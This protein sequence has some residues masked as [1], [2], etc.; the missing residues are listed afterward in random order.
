MAVRYCGDT[1]IRLRFD[2]GARVYVGHVVDP[3]LRFRG[4]VPASVA[5][6]HRNAPTSSE[7]YDLAARQLLHIAEGWARRHGRRFATDRKN[8]R[9]VVRRMF[10]SP[11]PLD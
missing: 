10:Q 11:C 3:F 7:A 8:G 5:R 4:V 1:E 9:P 6:Q 2:D